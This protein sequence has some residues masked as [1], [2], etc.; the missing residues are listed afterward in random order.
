MELVT[1]NHR[2]RR[3]S[4]RLHFG[5]PPL[6]ARSLGPREPYAPGLQGSCHCV[7]SIRGTSNLDL[8]RQLQLLA[9]V[10]ARVIWHGASDFKSF[11]SSQ[12]KAT[13]FFTSSTRKTAKHYFCSHCGATGSAAHASIRADGPSTSAASMAS[14]CRPF[15]IRPFD[16]ANWEGG[17]QGLLGAPQGNRAARQST[18]H[19]PASCCM[20][21]ISNGWALMGTRRGPEHKIV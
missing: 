15:E 5:P 14:T 3:C 9:C 8:R 11:V 21:A 16:G 20:P 17:C 1:P 18:A 4:P 6:N 19:A 2:C 12:A 7:E 13:G 10:V